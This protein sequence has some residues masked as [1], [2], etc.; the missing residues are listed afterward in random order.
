MKYEKSNTKNKVFSMKNLKTYL[1]LVCSLATLASCNDFLD[2]MPDDRTEVDTKAK[3]SNI[4]V[5]A[6]PNVSPILIAELSSDNAKDNGSLFD[7]YG[8]IS[9]DSYLWRDMNAADSDSPK[10]LWDAHYNAIAAANQALQSIELLG[11]TEDLAPQKGEALICRAFAHFQ[12]ANLF[13][14]AYNEDTA[15]KELGL[16]YTTAPE[17]EVMPEGIVRGT[18]QELYENINQDIEEGL[19]MIND[20]AYNVPKYHFNKRAAYA[21]A[22]RFNL[23]YHKF[24]KVVE[25]ADKVLGDNPQNEVR[26]WAQF[27]ELP[28]DFE[29][30]CNAYIAH[31][32]PCNLMLLTAQS[33]WPY[34]HGPYGIGLRYGNA[35]EI[36]T[37]EI[38][39]GPWG[40][41][42]NIALG[43]SVWGLD[44]KYCLS[45]LNGYFE[46][47]DKT[48]GIGFL[49]LVNVAFSTDELLLCRAEAQL[50]KQQPEPDKAVA[51]INVLMNSMAE[52]TFTKE[53]LIN[54]YNVRPYMPLHLKKESERTI[55][56][57][58][59]PQGFTIPDK[60]TE[61]LIQCVLHLRRIV[62]VHEGMRWQDIKRY[63]IELSH[64]RD[65]RTDDELLVNDPRRAIQ[66]PAEVITAGL[67]PNPRNNQ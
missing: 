33:S 52:V 40:D 50:L 49:H 60:D 30:R 51:D 48:S 67:E 44:Q 12:L 11:D 36:M 5:S 39:T 15:D 61:N 8:Q 24:D 7:I 47:I 32:E 53:E 54:Y 46:Y 6:Y 2:T 21:F 59:H 28:T 64:N 26:N 35:F 19:P 65:G 66:L 14:M 38:M 58:L 43:A 29:T 25:Y 62:T 63:G 1:L 22:A 56:K 27:I 3:I 45:K 42:F 31:T 4:L 9:Q 17:T 55:K 16:P 13:C 34:V 18:L 41:I 20:E 10:F 57:E 37:T 23:Y